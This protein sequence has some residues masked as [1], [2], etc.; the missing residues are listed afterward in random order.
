VKRYWPRGGAIG[1]RI[2]LGVNPATPLLRVIGVTGSVKIADLAETTRQGQIYLPFTQQE[3]HTVW[4]AA[5]KSL[6]DDPAIVPSI[7]TAL[8]SVYPELAMFD[9]KD[10]D[11]RLSVSMRDRK[12]AMVIC[13]VFAALALALSSLGI[14]GVLAFTVT[15]RTREFGIRLA[16]G[17]NRA[18]VLGMAARQG[19]TI[20]AT[21]G[22]RIEASSALRH[23]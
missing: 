17:A 8:Q 20:P 19:L 5:V 9:V 15:Q 10:I 7:R 16:L 14:Y 22:I 18:A 3:G 23:E 4:H 6:T 21:R 13:G 12:A 2:R 11:E 1:A